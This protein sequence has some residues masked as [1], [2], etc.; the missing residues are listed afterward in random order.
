MTRPF[1]VI[2]KGRKRLKNPTHV[3]IFLLTIYRPVGIIKVMDTRLK[4]IKTGASLFAKKS[5]TEVTIEEVVR[6]ANFSKG[7]FYH[8]FSSKENFYIEII[9]EAGKLFN[10]I[11]IEKIKTVD[12]S[13]EK[14]RAFIESALEFFQVEKNLYLVIQNEINK[15]VA[16]KDTPFS[17][18][19]KE[20]LLNIKSLVPDNNDPY[21][22]YFVMGVLRSAIVFK[23]QNNVS[24]NELL[25]K[26]WGYVSKSMEVQK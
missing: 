6:K 24:A 23:V 13:Y 8:Y 9:K 1:T 19:Q 26:I 20:T 25:N 18:F 16:G 15:I 3:P 12:S 21:F 11:F 7:A 4:L 5:F 22:P 14:L 10:Q 2:L 17:Q